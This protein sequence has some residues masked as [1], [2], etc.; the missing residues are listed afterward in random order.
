MY[1]VLR[2]MN[3]NTTLLKTPC[4]FTPKTRP[5]PGKAAGKKR[6]GKTHERLHRQ[7]AKI[8]QRRLQ[9]GEIVEAERDAEW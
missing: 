9:K 5:L 8:E 7:A 4:S 6:E 1:R 3:T 2:R